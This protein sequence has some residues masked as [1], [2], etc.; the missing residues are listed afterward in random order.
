MKKIAISTALIAVV[1]LVAGSVAVAGEGRGGHGGVFSAKMNGYNEVPLA[2]STNGRGRFTARIRFEQDSIRYR[3]TYNGLE[4]G[5]VL[6]AHLHLGQKHTVGGVFAFLCG[7]GGK[8]ACPA[9]GT[10][11]GE[12]KASDI[13]A[14]PA[15]GIAAGELDEAIRAIRKGAVYA[16]LHT[17]TYPAGEIRGQVERGAGGTQ[18]GEHDED[19]DEEKEWERR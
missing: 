13:L 16:N 15:Q 10:A 18:H 9:K 19:E 1:L 4:G 2:I 11:S 6:F 17:R 14:L 7:G 12:I 5:D 3:L 8:P